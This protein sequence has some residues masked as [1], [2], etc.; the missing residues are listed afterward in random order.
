MGQAFDMLKE[1]LEDIPDHQKG[2]KKLRTRMIEVPEPAINYSAA[3]V[4]RIRESLQYS[5]NVFAKFLNVSARTVESWE[6]GRRSP[7]H[8]AL[9]LLQ[10]VEQGYYPPRNSLRSTKATAI[11]AN[12]SSGNH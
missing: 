5:Q 2:I 7:S 1:G 3:D 9:R 4:K 10:I 8:A 6:S 11:P 12:L